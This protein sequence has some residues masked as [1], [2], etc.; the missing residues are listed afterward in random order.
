MHLS[1]SSMQRIRPKAQA[2][3]LPPKVILNGSNK[4]GFWVYSD[5]CAGRTPSEEGGESLRFLVRVFARP[6]SGG[7]G[8]QPPEQ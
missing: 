6:Q 5:D 1:L 3:L 4:D 7:D 8:C 2:A